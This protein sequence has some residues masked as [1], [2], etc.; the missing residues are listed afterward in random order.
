MYTETDNAEGGS[1]R[2]TGGANSLKGNADMDWGLYQ[3]TGI[4][5]KMLLPG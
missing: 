5:W 3:D 4:W 2:D 1:G